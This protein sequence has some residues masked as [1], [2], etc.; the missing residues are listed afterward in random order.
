MTDIIAIIEHLDDC[1]WRLKEITK[2]MNWF[3]NMGL[4]KCPTCEQPVLGG[5]ESNG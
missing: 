5:E 1:R 4:K 3:N 2:T